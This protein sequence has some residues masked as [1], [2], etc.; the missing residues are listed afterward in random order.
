MVEGKRSTNE[1]YVI[2]LSDVHECE[3]GGVVKL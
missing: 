3:V 2:L 1:E